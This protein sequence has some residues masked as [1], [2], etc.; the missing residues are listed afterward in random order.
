MDFKQIKNKN[1]YIYDDKQEFLLNVSGGVVRHNWR[2]GDEGE[3]VFTDDEYVCQIL[4]KTYINKK[5]DICIRTVCGT[6]LAKDMDKNMLGENG[7]PEN[8]YT[9]SGKNVGQ[10][11]FN[12]KNRTASELM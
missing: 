7:I 3:W 8:I 1:H 6:F 12:K 2:H 11:K 5:K 10:E 9:F 4:R